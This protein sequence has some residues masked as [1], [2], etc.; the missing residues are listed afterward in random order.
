VPV[1]VGEQR[2]DSRQVG[3]VLTFSVGEKDVDGTPS[4]IG[5]VVREKTASVLSGDGALLRVGVADDNSHNTGGRTGSKVGLS[6][7]GEVGFELGEIGRG[8]LD[9]DKAGADLRA[10]DS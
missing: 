10:E 7:L 8:G 1:N 2:L 6:N 9:M 3:H 4:R 5:I